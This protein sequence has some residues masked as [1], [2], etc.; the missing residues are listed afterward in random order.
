[1]PETLEHKYVNSTTSL[2][3]FSL[4]NFFLLRTS[5]DLTEKRGHV[6]A[7]ITAY[8]DY[9]SSQHIVISYETF[10]ISRKTEGKMD[11]GLEKIEELQSQTRFGFE[12]TLE[13]SKK[14]EGKMDRG[15][16]KIEELQRQA[17]A[18]MESTLR[19]EHNVRS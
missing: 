17:H 4:A 6:N 2:L 13:T 11:K 14:T 9:M 12:S 8:N 15:L 5:R 1:M 7:A 19:V 18:G 10:E 3:M 16:D